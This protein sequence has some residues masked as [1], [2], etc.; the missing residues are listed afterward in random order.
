MWVMVD[1]LAQSFLKTSILFVI[2][3]FIN[4][5]ELHATNRTVRGTRAHTLERAHSPSCYV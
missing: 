4:L 1:L 2:F 5:L 3:F